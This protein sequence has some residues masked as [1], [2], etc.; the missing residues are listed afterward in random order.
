MSRFCPLAILLGRVGLAGGRDWPAENRS[1]SQRVVFRGCEE[2]S[3]KEALSVQ[4]EWDFASAGV[5]RLQGR[6]T[7][8]EDD[9][10]TRQG[11]QPSPNGQLRRLPASGQH[12]DQAGSLYG[13]SSLRRRI[14]ADVS[15]L[16]M[17]RWV[18]CLVQ[19]TSHFVF[20][21]HASQNRQFCLTDRHHV[22]TARRE[23]TA[24][25]LSERARQIPVQ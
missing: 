9:E 11:S 23:R 25:P 2:E 16:F 12:R 13:P 24:Y 10:W 1:R 5:H 20:L 21:L 18:A 7:A 14:V 19:M 22:S 4:P 15:R 6:R 8:E 3:C 17:N